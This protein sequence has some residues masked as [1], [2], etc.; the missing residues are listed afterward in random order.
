MT[1]ARPGGSGATWITVDANTLGG[2]QLNADADILEFRGDVGGD[3][4]EVSDIE[5]KL[6]F[7]SNVDNTAGNVADT[8]DFQ[9]VCYYKGTGDIVNKTQ[10]VTDSCTV[11]QIDDH[12]QITCTL[13]VNYDEAGNVVD[14]GDKFTFVLNVVTGTSDVADITMNHIH[15][16][17]KTKQV[18][19]EV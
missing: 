18:G 8:T 15:I 7:E 17:Y 13:L 1:S 16:R 11:G 2:W 19:V 12:E 4:D 3:W 5:I 6:I 9:V 10:I 14:V